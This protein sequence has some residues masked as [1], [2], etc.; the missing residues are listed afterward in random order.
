MIRS[1]FVLEVLLVKEQ[2]IPHPNAGILGFSEFTMS[3]RLLNTRLS[4]PLNKNFRSDR[5]GR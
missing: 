4:D 5:S 2:V 1:E 3:S